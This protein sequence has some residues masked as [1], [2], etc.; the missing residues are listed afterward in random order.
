MKSRGSWDGHTIR[1]GC[2]KTHESTRTSMIAG[3]QGDNVIVS[4]V[5][6][7]KKYR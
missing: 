2:R 7:R 5:G 4:R 1:L 6:L 3:L